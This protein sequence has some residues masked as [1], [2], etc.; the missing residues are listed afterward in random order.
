MNAL[1]G[2]LLVVRKNRLNL[3][4]SVFRFIPPA[5]LLT[6]AVFVVDD[7]ISVPC[8]HLRSAFQVRFLQCLVRKLYSGQQRWRQ[9]RNLRP[10]DY[11]L[12][13]QAAAVC[14]PTVRQKKN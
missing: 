3:F 8:G 12:V 6:E 7:D 4:G 5:S 10:G 9:R 1:T 13:D 14:K 11:N 2:K